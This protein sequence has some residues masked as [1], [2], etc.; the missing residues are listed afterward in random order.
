MPRQI[1]ERDF[2]LR[3]TVRIVLSAILGFAS[4][5]G[6]Y[7]IDKLQP[8]SS[9]RDRVTDVLTFPGF[10]IARLFYLVG[11]HT[12]SGNPDLWWAFFLGNS[13]FYAVL[14]YFILDVLHLPPEFSEF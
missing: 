9:I 8:Y 2:V 13:F 3:V 7:V 1:Y 5:E 12:G 4:T 14:C 6:L 10:M 11:I